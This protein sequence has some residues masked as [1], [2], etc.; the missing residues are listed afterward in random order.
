[1]SLSVIRERD[2]QLLGSLVMYH[3]IGGG[4]LPTLGPDPAK[5]CPL[6]VYDNQ[7]LRTVFVP[8]N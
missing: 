5:H 4:L 2:E 8:A 1:M 6:N 7:F 3:R